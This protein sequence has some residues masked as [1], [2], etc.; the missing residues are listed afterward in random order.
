MN[1][2]SMPKLEVVGVSLTPQSTKSRSIK[3]SSAPLSDLLRHDYGT[4]F[5][6]SVLLKVSCINCKVIHFP[7][8]WPHAGILVHS[9]TWYFIKS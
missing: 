9:L 7:S 4:T 2:A 6:S 8:R 1:S 3:Q 5:Q